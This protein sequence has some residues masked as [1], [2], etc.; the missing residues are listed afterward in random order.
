MIRCA[1]WLFAASQILDVRFADLRYFF[2][3]L[4]DALLDGLGHGD[5]AVYGNGCLQQ[6]FLT[7]NAKRGDF[8]LVGC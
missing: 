6:L 1:G 8:P 2:P 4:S 3:Q 7:I 5:K